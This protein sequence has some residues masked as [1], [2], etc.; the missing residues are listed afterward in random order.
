MVDGLL[1]KY[2]LVSEN[3]IIKEKTIFDD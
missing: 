2:D 3:V 1:E